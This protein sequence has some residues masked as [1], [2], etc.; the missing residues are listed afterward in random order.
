MLS[1]VAG[2]LAV[3]VLAVERSADDRG[4]VVLAALFGLFGL[5]GFLAARRGVEPDDEGV[6]L[7][8]IVRSR[9]VRWEDVAYFGLA[10]KRNWFGERAQRPLA[11]LRS[12]ERLVVPGA[13]KMSWLG[14]GPEGTRFSVLD[15]LE[16]LRN[17]RSRIL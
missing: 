4:P 15:T 13:D 3:A 1:S 9:F 12:G 6:R 7:R 14:E 16:R 10:E 11:V 17:E 8:Y 2:L 5:W